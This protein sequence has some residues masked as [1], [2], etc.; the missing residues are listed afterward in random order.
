MA[1]PN[2][3]TLPLRGEATLLLDS[4]YRSKFLPYRFWGIFYFDWLI[5]DW[6]FLKF[7]L[8][9]GSTSPPSISFQYN[10]YSMLVLPPVIIYHRII[11]PNLLYKLRNLSCPKLP[12]PWGGTRG[13]ESK[14]AYTYLARFVWKYSTAFFDSDPLP[15]PTGW[16]LSFGQHSFPS[17]TF[18][19]SN[20]ISLLFTEKPPL[21]N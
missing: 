17:E 14:N 8:Y 19:W 15:S 10:M 16:G 21:H 1:V 2:T 6:R 7:W 9:K 3:W 12:P 4:G 18:R 20:V 13:S 11:S 5:L